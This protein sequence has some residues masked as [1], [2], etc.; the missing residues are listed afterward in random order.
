MPRTECETLG[1]AHLGAA[2]QCLRLT[3]DIMQ[4]RERKRESYCQIW[5]A[6]NSRLQSWALIG[7]QCKS[8]PLMENITSNSDSTIWEH[9]TIQSECWRRQINDRL[10]KACLWAI[11]HQTLWVPK[12]NQLAYLTQINVGGGWSAMNDQRFRNNRNVTSSK[13]WMGPTSG[14]TGFLES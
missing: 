4:W 2:A 3:M 7:R 1:H 5:R 10:H 8:I 11:P 12:C 14:V 6:L 9:H 13:L